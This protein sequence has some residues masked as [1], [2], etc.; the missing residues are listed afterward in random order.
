MAKIELLALYLT[1]PLGEQK[2]VIKINLDRL[3]V[4]KTCTDFGNWSLDAQKAELL[5]IYFPELDEERKNLFPHC[6]F[7]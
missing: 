6:Q 1:T 4:H 7:Q 2:L 3:T 5:E